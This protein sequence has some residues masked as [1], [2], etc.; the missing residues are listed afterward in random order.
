MTALP[1][2]WL[3]VYAG[4]VLSQA[5]HLAEHVVQM[6]QIHGLGVA[7]PEARGV[8]GT[9]DLEWVHFLWNVGILGLLGLLLLRVP[10][11]PWSWLAFGVAAWHSAEHT[12]ILAR[13]LST[14]VAGDP[15]LLGAGGIALG[16][17]PIARPDL[18][19]LY[20]LVEATLLAAG[21]TGASHSSAA[22]AASSTVQREPAA[23]RRSTSSAPRTPTSR[24]RSPWR[25]IA[26][27]P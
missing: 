21:F 27:S 5:G 3:I 19:F 8:V 10:R 22:S 11:N 18:H 15:G 26:S 9:L 6:V 16:G 13:Y 23:R 2:G 20:N 24:P 25:R 1:S 7:A 4:L 17:L 14:G 12:V